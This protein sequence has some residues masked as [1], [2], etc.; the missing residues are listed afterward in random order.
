MVNTL[1][2]IDNGQC[3]IKVKVT[4]G[5]RNFPHI[6]QCKL[7]GPLTQLWYKLGG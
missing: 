7:S 3:Q 1:E 5:L 4:V 2:K 6:P